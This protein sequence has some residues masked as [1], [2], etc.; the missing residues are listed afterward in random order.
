[1]RYVRVLGSPCPSHDAHS[2]Q[3]LISNPFPPP[4]VLGPASAPPSFAFSSDWVMGA[5]NPLSGSQQMAHVA[6]D[7]STCVIELPKWAQRDIARSLYQ[8][9][10]YSGRTGVRQ[11][12]VEEKKDQPERCDEGAAGRTS[13]WPS[14]GM[15]DHADSTANAH[16]LVTVVQTPNTTY[17]SNVSLP[18]AWGL[19]NEPGNNSAMHGLYS[20]QQPRRPASAGLLDRMLMR[21]I[22]RQCR[23]ASS[24]GTPSC[25]IADSEVRSWNPL[26]A[27]LYLSRRH[28]QSSIV[29]LCPRCL[30]SSIG[31]AHA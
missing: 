4:D 6:H 10:H 2:M 8:M 29:I 30:I 22:P 18:Q 17:C 5:P 9:N 21:G 20:W 24:A 26:L 14:P 15:S 11:R 27:V 19:R 23:Q 31:A 3:R 25:S 28:M 1:M 13:A 16:S 7:T 12:Q